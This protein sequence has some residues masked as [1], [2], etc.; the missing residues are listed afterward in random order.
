[1]GKTKCGKGTKRVLVTEGGGLPL[2]VLM[3]T[4]SRNM[5]KLVEPALATVHVRRAGRGRPRQKPEGLLADREMDADPLRE[6]LAARGI[7][8]IIPHRDNRVK[9]AWVGQDG[10]T[11]RRYRRRW[12]I[13]RTFGWL[14]HFR[15]LLVR[16]EYLDLMHEGFFK[17]GCI[18]IVL[19]QL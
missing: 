9:P 16:H 10:R 11:L 17:L 19:R 14:G 8:P 5:V 15:R 6:R 13:E 1:M 4:A 7:Q 2:G 18:L 12:V 3:A